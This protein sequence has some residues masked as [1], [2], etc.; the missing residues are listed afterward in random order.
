MTGVSPHVFVV[1]ATEAMVIR[2][3]DLRSRSL[4]RRGRRSDQIK[5]R[6]DFVRVIA[7]S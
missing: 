4:S 5:L 3:K 2:G 7:I 1:E 6:K